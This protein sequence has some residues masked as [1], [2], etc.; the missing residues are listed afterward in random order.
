MTEGYQ[1]QFANVEYME[2]L[3]SNPHDSRKTAQR[4]K[5]ILD[6]GASISTLEQH[7]IDALGLKPIGRTNVTIA[8]GQTMTRSVYVVDMVLGTQHVSTVVLAAGLNLM[9]IGTMKQLGFRICTSKKSASAQSRTHT[10]LVLVL[11][12][13]LIINTGLAVYWMRAN[14]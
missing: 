6:T 13:A 12:A 14:K 1:P 10:I 4:V 3:L 11:A 5:C 8:D 9:G 7:V 2:V